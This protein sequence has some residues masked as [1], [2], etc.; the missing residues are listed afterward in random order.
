M[1]LAYQTPQGAD[2][3]LGVSGAYVSAQADAVT[4]RQ[5]I[6]SYS[7]GAELSRDKLSVGGAYVSRGD[8]NSLVTGLDEAEWNIGVAWRDEKWGVA[9]SAAVTSSTAL[10]NQLIG[11]GGYYELGR[12]WVVRAD[13]VSIKEKRP[14]A[15]DHDGLVGI[16]EI[17][18]RF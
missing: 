11:V 15:A 9:G 14:A 16:A 7:I 1:G 18:F 8:S 4:Q 5:D 12:W 2:W 6:E 10:D 17:S 3:A 13:V